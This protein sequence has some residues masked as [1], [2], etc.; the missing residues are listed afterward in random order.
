MR[1]ETTQTDAH[2]Q[3][4][5]GRGTMDLR[6]WGRHR[7]DR[8]MRRRRSQYS[9]LIIIVTMERT[10]TSHSSC[11]TH[12]IVSLDLSLARIPSQ[13]GIIRRDALTNAICRRDFRQ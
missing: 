10:K 13:L 6:Y 2:G 11:R 3:T 12:D 5:G 7:Q 1:S 8:A 4:A 9:A